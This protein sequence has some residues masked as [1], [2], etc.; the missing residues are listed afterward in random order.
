MDLQ[1]PKIRPYLWDIFASEVSYT[2]SPTD[3]DWDVMTAWITRV[4]D[5]GV[6]FFNDPEVVAFR[7]VVLQTLW[8]GDEDR[9]VAVYDR[10]QE[11]PSDQLESANIEYQDILAHQQI[12]TGLLAGDCIWFGA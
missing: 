3:R 6:D 12:I 1:D 10:I 2:A 7:Q 5:M 11:V 8:Q 4:K 9:R